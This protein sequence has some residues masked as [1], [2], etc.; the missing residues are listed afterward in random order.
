MLLP[1]GKFP[2]EF[3]LHIAPHLGAFDLYH[4][5]TAYDC[6][7]LYHDLRLHVF[8]SH[9]DGSVA[10]YHAIRMGRLD[11]LKEIPNIRQLITAID[12]LT[13]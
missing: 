7:G 4:L 5:L 6:R 11:L 10:L 13:R 9:Q 8:N 1:M 2:L 3:I 12:K